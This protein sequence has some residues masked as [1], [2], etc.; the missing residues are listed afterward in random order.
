MNL[1]K[2]R[3]SEHPSSLPVDS[4]LA[5]KTSL[6]DELVLATLNNKFLLVYITYV[7]DNMHVIY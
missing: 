3:T 2:S 1:P 5:L 7:S 6:S 4:A